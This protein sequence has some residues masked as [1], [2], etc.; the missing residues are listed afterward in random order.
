LQYFFKSIVVNSVRFVVFVF[1]ILPLLF[2]CVKN[3]P[4]PSWLRVN[5]WD[6]VAN[7][8]LS[9]EEGELTEK[10]TN[11][12]VYVNDELIGIFE[13]PF[14]I[15]LLYSGESRIRLDPV[16]INNGISATKKVYPFTNF[17]E[18]TITLIQN[19]TVVISPVTSYKT[20]AKFWIEDFEDVNISIQNDPNTSLA[21]LILSNESLNAFNGNYY[22]KVVLTE[23]DSTWVAYTLDPL[24]IP[25]GVDSFLEIDY[26]NT[27]DVYQG[28]IYVSPSSGIE[29]N[30][31]IRMNA[32]TL[33]SA[34]WK[35]MYI[36][37]RELVTASPLQSTF[38]QSFQANLDPD[39]TE[40]L[41]CLDNIKVI[42]F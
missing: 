5:D 40:G 34:V 8:A 19:D 30:V 29:D 9:G 20:N 24:S 16:I 21:N 37:L 28:L 11:A 10:I 13:T 1:I 42:W 32:Q 35:K 2:S 31:N 6:L 12:K 27:N 22:G 14:R 18:E 7:V 39:D 23:T 36:E 4:D 17:Y 33:E 26:Y 3:N 25:K 15:P 41:I 38:L